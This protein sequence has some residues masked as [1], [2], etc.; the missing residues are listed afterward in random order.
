MP[1]KKKAENKDALATTDN[2]ANSIEEQEK[3]VKFIDDLIKQNIKIEDAKQKERMSDYN[4]LVSITSEWLDSFFI[5]GYNL[6]GEELVITKAINSKDYN[7]LL[8]LLKKAFINFV[9]KSEIE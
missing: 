5:I 9:V 2:Y 7:S 4:N 8:V 6:R 3:I 1:R